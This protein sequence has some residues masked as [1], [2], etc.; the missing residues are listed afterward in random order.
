MKK[1]LRV[2]ILIVSIIGLFNNSIYATSDDV[3]LSIIDTSAETKY[4]EN[5]Q[6]YISKKI[7]NSDV[8]KGEVTIELKVSNTS[9]K[10]QESV[11]TEVLIVADN[12]ASMNTNSNGTTRKKLITNAIKVLV[13][14][15][16]DQNSN[17]QVGLIRFSE[18]P[19][20]MCQL[21]NN[22]QTILNS[23]N[24]FDNLATESNTNISTAL[25]SA[26]S[27][28]SADCKNKIIVLLTDGIPSNDN[29]GV[30]TKNTLNTVS[31]SGT[32]II[33]MVTGVNSPIINTIFGTEK[34]PTVGK[35]YNIE[36]TSINEVISNNI[37]KDIV[38]TM[39]RPIKN[40]TITDYFPSDIIDNFEFS[41]VSKPTIGN[42]S[43]EIDKAN[44]SIIW[45]MDTLNVGEDA[46]V[47]YKIK[48]KDKN[49][50]ELLDK[51]LPTN[52]KVLL[53]YKDYDSK[54][55][56]VEI[57]TTPK[58]KLSKEKD[59]TIKNSVLPNTGTNLKIVLALILVG[60]IVTFAMYKVSEKYKKIK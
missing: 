6:G 29:T 10:Q 2:I 46:S 54:E 24:A 45:K 57:N 40:I 60:T 43:E 34:S 5:D 56:S 42:I 33:S 12:S 28:F 47:Q 52:E 48:L 8:N 15:L 7:V 3:I 41:Y 19:N 20:M 39:Q 49:N 50:Q 4:F 14:Q 37:F 9:K 25:T 17:I 23:I 32:Y 44:K 51:I 13:N 38:E 30:S 26:N 21:T 22:K 11:K 36:D 18:I 59:N 31:N 58:I 16:Y 53:T 35:F 1:I 55:Y 27:K